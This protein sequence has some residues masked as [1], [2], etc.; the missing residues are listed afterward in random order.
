MAARERRDRRPFTAA[1][2]ARPLTA[3]MKA[4]SWRGMNERRNLA[5]DSAQIMA[6]PRQAF[7]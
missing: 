6:W 4:A 1:W 7:E 2:L 3:R 5:S